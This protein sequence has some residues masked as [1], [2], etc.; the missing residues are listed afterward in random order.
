MWS[1]TPIPLP[2]SAT[3]SRTCWTA[4]RC[5]QAPAGDARPWP[6][7]SS[8][9]REL[10]LSQPLAASG[11]HDGTVLWL[12]RPGPA[13]DQ[14]SGL[15]TVRAVAG[16]EAGRVWYLDAGEHRIGSGADLPH[17]RGWRPAEVV[18]VVRVSLDAAV[19]VRAVVASGAARPRATART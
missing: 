6:S 19:R 2:S 8:A 4:C 11:I 17:H 1:S 7:L 5:P 16:A 12:D 18:A 14:P 9:D 15:V 13:S 10:D 3:S